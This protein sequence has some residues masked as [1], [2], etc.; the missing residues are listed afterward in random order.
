MSTLELARGCCAPLQTP[1][2]SRRCRSNGRTGAPPPDPRTGA[3]TAER[4]TVVVAARVTRAE[5]VAVLGDRE[6]DAK[7][8]LGR[9]M[10][11]LPADS[12]IG[13][14]RFRKAALLDVRAHQSAIATGVISSGST[15]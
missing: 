11:E 13:A 1:G 8:F 4:G 5:Q 15:L 3:L 14:D 2:V 7:A 6:V 9:V 10:E 12:V